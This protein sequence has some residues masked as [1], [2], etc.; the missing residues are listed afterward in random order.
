M[1]NKIDDFEERAAIRE[2][3]DDQP[4]GTAEFFA[5]KEI[6]AKKAQEECLKRKL[7]YEKK[8]NE[9][10]KLQRTSSQS[11]NQQRLE[12]QNQRDEVGEKMRAEKEPK[13][14]DE[15]FAEWMRLTTQIIELRKG[16]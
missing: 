4:R 3:D 7:E 8:Q 14:K 6:D 12:L 10:K 5:H 11:K 16:V 15:L 9:Q 13:R 1:Q 2:F